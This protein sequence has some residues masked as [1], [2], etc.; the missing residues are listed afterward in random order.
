MKRMDDLEFIDLQ[1]ELEKN[2]IIWNPPACCDSR[3][4][5]YTL[6]RIQM[7]GCFHFSQ[8]GVWIDD[9]EHDEKCL[10][11]LQLTVKRSH[12]LVLFPEYCISNRVLRKI[13]ADKSLWP[14]NRKLWVLPCQGMPKEKFQNFIDEVSGKDQIFLLDKA[15][16]APQVNRRSFVTALFYC[17]LGYRDG[18][19][20]L[21]LVPQLKTQP[22]GDR[23]C[24]CEQAGMTTGCMIYTLNHRLLTLL[25]ADSMNND[26]TWGSFQE[27]LLRF[28]FTI[29]HPQLN[30]HPKDR[31]FS[32]IRWELFEHGGPGV[33]ITCNWAKGTALYQEGR[34][35]PTE[36]IDISWSC[37]YRKHADDIFGKWNQ[38][39]SLRQEN[40]LYG[41]FGAVM[42]S[43]RTEVWFSL[44]QEE[45]VILQIP[46]PS[47][48]GYGKLSIPDIHAQARFCYCQEA[49]E[50]TEQKVD[51]ET[52]Q[53]RIDRLPSGNTFLHQYSQDVEG[54][55][56]FA[57]DMPQRIDADQFFALALASF[58]N[59]ILEIDENENLNAWT[60][61]LDESEQESA[62][63][64]LDQLL[65]LIEILRGELPPQCAPLKE[66][67]RFCYQPAQIDRPSVNFQSDKQ[68]ALVAYAPSAIDTQKYIKIL[69][70]AE[71]HGDEDLLRRFVRVFY[72]EPKGNELN[73]EPQLSIDITQGDGISMRGDITNG[74]NESDF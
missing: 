47:F 59:N 53:Q 50:W 37:I 15:W 34:K 71:C 63:K 54:P 33:Y 43:K 32:R 31:V 27:E 51:P 18:K 74:G 64:A 52:L 29:L 30:A 56:R 57:L 73:C 5:S 10:S 23:N 39:G 12:D 41:L 2:Q 13:I 6:F 40:E 4:S 55:Y 20:V 72:Y 68:D 70:E 35:K 38:N 7:Q 9:P 26:L 58:H 36:N 24:L 49:K 22:M 1:E 25:C 60:L 46:N 19:P 44:Y 61:L 16:T 65:R 11:L 48:E 14:E 42:R 21:C 67:H 8:D 62:G 69:K 17:F 3:V 28:G 66:P 45:A